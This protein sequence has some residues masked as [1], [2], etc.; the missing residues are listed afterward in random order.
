MNI[1][2][3]KTDIITSL[4]EAKRRIENIY[5]PGLE[6]VF[7]DPNYKVMRELTSPFR[8]ALIHIEF[9]IQE[10]DPPPKPPVEHCTKCN[11]QIPTK[12]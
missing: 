8:L 12:E 6:P 4:S 7:N 3:A 5:D 9:A 2:D 1:Q 10:I 11:Q